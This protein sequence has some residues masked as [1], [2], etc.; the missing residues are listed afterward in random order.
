MIVVVLVEELGIAILLETRCRSAPT[1]VVIIV[2]A[3]VGD[4]L[5]RHVSHSRWRSV[6]LH[7]TNQGSTR[8]IEFVGS[9]SRVLI[10][11]F[12]TRNVETRESCL[13]IVNQRT[14]CQGCI[15]LLAL[16]EV[17]LVVGWLHENPTQLAGGEIVSG[18]ILLAEIEASVCLR[19]NQ[20]NPRI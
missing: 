10:H 6:V 3:W 5:V 14:E 8:C 2:V 4:V 13:R 17:C 19:W 16:G 18:G 1:I 20:T 15:I 12:R 9:G 7:E 11:A